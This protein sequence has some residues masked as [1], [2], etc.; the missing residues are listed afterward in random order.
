MY[1]SNK[2][3]YQNLSIIKIGRKDSLTKKTNFAIAHQ[4]QLN[5]ESIFIFLDYQ[6]AVTRKETCCKNCRDLYMY[7]SRSLICTQP[8]FACDW[9]IVW[10][11]TPYRHILLILDI[12]SGGKSVANTQ[13]TIHKGSVLRCM[14]FLKTKQDVFE[15]HKCFR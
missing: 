1:Y 7:R 12:I 5:C 2:T 15:K 3:W 13:C 10:S 14:K 9:L 11:T 8:Y 4:I 6:L